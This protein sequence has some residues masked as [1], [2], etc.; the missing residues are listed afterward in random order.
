M[1]LQPEEIGARIASARAEKEWSQFDLA[2]AFGVGPSTIYRWEAGRLP[3]SANKLIRLAEILDKP[4]DYLTEPPERQA[5]LGDL[6]GLLEE[7]SAEAE[8]GRNAVI[9]SLESFDFRL[10]RIETA[11]GI[12][13]EPDSEAR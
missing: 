7:A 5:E 6:R 13:D 3:S 11:L 12:Q 4:S 8:R 10:S 2:I 1:P 9:A